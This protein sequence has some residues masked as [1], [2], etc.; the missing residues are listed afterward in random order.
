VAPAG[1]LR[2]SLGSVVQETKT[3]TERTS[4]DGVSAP[5]RV[6]GSDSGSGV[7]GAKDTA[8]QVPGEKTAVPRDESVVNTRE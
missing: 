3:K 6:Q 2:P 4:N 1:A 8:L 7:V 5:P